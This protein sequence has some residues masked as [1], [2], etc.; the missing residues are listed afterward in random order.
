[1][2]S[3]N[4]NIFSSSLSKFYQKSIEERQKIIGD[5]CELTESERRLLRYQSYINLEEFDKISENIIGTYVLPFSIATNFIINGREVLVPMATEEPSVVAAASN[6]AKIARKHGGFKS[7]P[8][9]SIMIGQIQISDIRTN[10]EIQLLEDY[11]EKN[12]AAFLKIA[13]LLDPKLV[14]AGGG[15]RDITIR[16]IEISEGFMVILHIL[17]DVQNAMGANIVNTM[18][19]RLAMEL[20]DKIPGNIVLKIVS[21][22]ATERI[23]RSTAIFDKNLLGGSRVVSRILEAYRFAACDLYRACTHNKGIMNGIDA[24]AIATGNDFRALEAGAHT[25]ASKSGHYSPLTRF[26]MDENG[27]LVGHI[28][29]PLALGVIGGMTTKHPMAKL[30][31]NCMNI[32]TSEELSQIVAAVGLAQNLAALRA[33][34]DE[35]IQK[36]HMKLHLRKA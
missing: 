6:A 25:F 11:I 14:Q 35:G 5:L 8:I 17:I 33:L 7:E 3:K 4:S 12:K 22:F 24:V 20:Q 26:E 34:A 9:K 13:N 15:A 28:E 32:S 10:E 18:V 16:K 30:A 23:A 31:I 2:N 36:G 21:N 27:N 19:E 29:I 1:M